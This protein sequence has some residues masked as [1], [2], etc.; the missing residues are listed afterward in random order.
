MSD[1][2][3]EISVPHMDGMRAEQ[4]WLKRRSNKVLRQNPLETNSRVLR[5][6]QKRSAA[7]TDPNRSPDQVKARLRAKDESCPTPPEVIER[8]QED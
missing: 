2:R 7:G 8:L 6:L 4:R 1:S 3:N 5:R